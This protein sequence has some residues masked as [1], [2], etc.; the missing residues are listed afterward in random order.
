MI[1]TGQNGLKF[2]EA[3][4]KEILSI[5]PQLLASKCAVRVTL[6]VLSVGLV[7]ESGVRA[8]PAQSVRSITEKQKHFFG[9]EPWTSTATSATAPPISTSTAMPVCA[10]GAMPIS[11]ST[12][13]S[14]SAM[15]VTR[16]NASPSDR[17]YRSPPKS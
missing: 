1:R 2:M 15:S 6:F 3:S 4:V 16:D 14:L 17:Q 9:L 11:T 7:V 5:D 13:R 12:G 8:E 10:S